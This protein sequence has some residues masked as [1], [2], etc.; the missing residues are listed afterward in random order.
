MSVTNH[1]IP[2]LSPSIFRTAY[3]TRGAVEPGAYPSEPWALAGGHTGQGSGTF[4]KTQYL[5]NNVTM[6]RIPSW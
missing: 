4:S 1:V 2:A 5:S 3:P 6:G